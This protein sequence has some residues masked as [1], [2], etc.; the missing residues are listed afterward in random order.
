MTLGGSFTENFY[1]LKRVVAER[2]GGSGLTPKHKLS[3]LLELV[4]VPYLRFKL[5][6][7]GVPWISHVWAVYELSELVFQFAY[8]FGKSQFFTPL[9]WAQSILIARLTG[10]DMKRFNEHAA[11]TSVAWSTNKLKYLMQ[12]LTSMIKY[13][14]IFS[15]VLLKLFEYYSSPEN[16]AA[17]EAQ[18]RRFN[19]SVAPPPPLPPIPLPEATQLLS[20]PRLCPLCGEIRE[21]PA[22][23]SSGYC[24]CHKCIYSHVQQ[25]SKCPVTGAPCTT[26]E[27]RKVF[28]T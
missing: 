8:L 5:S 12:S 21:N 3:S 9:L 19:P 14:V 24:F 15:V 13:S 7:H 23:S 27:I 10:E 28:A 22:L 17:R 11:S 1:G 6:R 16:R 25:Y 4:F 26:L 18:Q 2:S 20:D